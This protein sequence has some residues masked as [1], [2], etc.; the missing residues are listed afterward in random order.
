[1]LL[2]LLLLVQSTP[3]MLIPPTGASKIIQCGRNLA[4]TLDC[5]DV[6]FLPSVRASRTGNL[7]TVQGPDVSRAT[8][9]Q[10][11][12]GSFYDYQGDMKE[13]TLPLTMP[14]NYFCINLAPS[15][16]GA[17]VLMY[18]AKLRRVDDSTSIRIA[19]LLNGNGSGTREYKLSLSSA[20]AWPGTYGW[21]SPVPQGTMHYFPIGP[22]CRTFPAISFDTTEDYVVEDVFV[23]VSIP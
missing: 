14:K 9:I 15:G 23:F 12:G 5:Y 7:L 10:A 3:E 16:S 1:M 2:S 4:G 19:G 22:G 8:W 13:V 6:R 21:E 11:V 18:D 20:V 17:A